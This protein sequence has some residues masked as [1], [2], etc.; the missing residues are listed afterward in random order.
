MQRIMQR[1]YCARILKK[2]TFFV[3]LESRH[4]SEIALRNWNFFWF[5][6]QFLFWKNNERIIH[7]R[8]DVFSGFSEWK[9]S[10]KDG[11]KKIGAAFWYATTDMKWTDVIVFSYFCIGKIILD[12]INYGRLTT[13]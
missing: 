8:V 13:Y 10:N 11:K 3:P 6:N 4:G 7:V 12:T 1:L 2:I 9:F 5:Y